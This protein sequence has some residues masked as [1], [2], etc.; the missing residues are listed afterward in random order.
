MSEFAG[1]ALP[2]QLNLNPMTANYSKQTPLWPWIALLFC[3]GI[4]TVGAAA[5]IGWVVLALLGY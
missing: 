5:L 3:V 4:V 2:A 1:G